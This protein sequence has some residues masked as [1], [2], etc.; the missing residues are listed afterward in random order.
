ML[1]YKSLT[2]PITKSRVSKHAIYCPY[3]PPGLMK[4]VLVVMVVKEEGDKE[5]G[6]EKEGVV[7]RGTL[8]LLQWYLAP[9]CL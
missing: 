5:K 1:I 9:Y 3:K 2:L 7:E 4:E 8:F 6:V